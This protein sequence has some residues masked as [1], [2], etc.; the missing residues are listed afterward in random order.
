MPERNQ[1]RRMRRRPSVVKFDKS[2]VLGEFHFK[3]VVKFNFVSAESL[4]FQLYNACHR[5][6]SL[7]L[8]SDG[9]RYEI[10]Y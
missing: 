7:N 6:G 9:G 2:S 5:I 3:I 1:M 10:K 8:L 4:G